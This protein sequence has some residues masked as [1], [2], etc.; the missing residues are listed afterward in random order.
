VQRKTEREKGLEGGRERETKFR[1]GQGEREKGGRGQRKD[2]ES[3]AKDT[4]MQTERGNWG[5]GVRG[6]GREEGEGRRR[7]EKDMTSSCEV[8]STTAWCVCRLPILCP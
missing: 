7:E 4:D 5:A 8:A 1:G 3:I 6:G 2:G